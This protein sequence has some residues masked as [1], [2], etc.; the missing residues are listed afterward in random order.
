[1]LER[2]TL[3]RHAE[4]GEPGAIGLQY[5]ARSVNLFQ[6]GCLLLVESP[7]RGDVTLK[8]AQ[9]T[10][11]ILARLGSLESI[12]DGFSFQAAVVCQQFFNPGPI[13]AT[14]GL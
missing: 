8:G 10:V 3:D 6:D 2:L 11:L 7:P 12:E 4:F 5:L 13:S 9:L 1:M 14:S